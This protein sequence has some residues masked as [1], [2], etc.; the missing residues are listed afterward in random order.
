MSCTFIGINGVRSDGSAT[1]GKLLLKL[2]Q[3]YECYV[4]R[5][6]Y[7]RIT[8]FDI[9]TKINSFFRQPQYQIA[10]RLINDVEKF[11][12]ETVNI[13]AHSFGCLI[14]VR[15]LELGMKV[16]NLFFFS[17]A[18]DS[19]AEIP[20]SNV[21]GSVYVIHNPR[22]LA[23]LMGSVLLF[24]D[25]GG[26]GNRGSINKKKDPKIINVPYSRPNEIEFRIF[27]EFKELFNLN[28][29][30]YFFDYNLSHWATFVSSRTNILE[31]KIS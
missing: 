3:D 18:I 22:D 28:H 14:A 9:F 17:P 12:G 20:T 24:H 16:D 26:M 25:F 2:V 21:S 31:K 29:I 4:R 10:R 1:T 6:E 30:S 13:I 19:D 8:L 7:R 27:D 11:E 23:I 15:A 5:F